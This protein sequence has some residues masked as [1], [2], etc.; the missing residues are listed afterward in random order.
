MM[1][2]TAIESIES[3]IWYNIMFNILKIIAMTDKNL[4]SLSSQTDCP[5]W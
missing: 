5:F 3:N 4:L 2:L 1:T